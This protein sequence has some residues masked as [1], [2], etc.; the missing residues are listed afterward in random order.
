MSLN[1]SMSHIKCS[2][3][4]VV[5]AGYYHIMTQTA[6]KRPFSLPFHSIWCLIFIDVTSVETE[7]FQSGR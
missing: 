4:S 7:F 1:V 5:L 2:A 3:V 6:N